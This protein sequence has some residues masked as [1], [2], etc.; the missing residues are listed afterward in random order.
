MS[1][2][3]LL[4]TT[5]RISRT[6]G[7]ALEASDIMSST[8]SAQALRRS[9]MSRSISGYSTSMQPIDGIQLLRKHAPLLRN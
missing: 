6:V 5:S 7:I 8:Q 2:S 9:A 1:A 3:I 4:W